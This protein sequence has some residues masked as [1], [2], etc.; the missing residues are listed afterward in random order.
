[1]IYT[2][3]MMQIKKFKLT[4][5]GLS[6]EEFRTNLYKLLILRGQ[7]KEAKHKNLSDKFYQRMYREEN[8]LRIRKY[9]AEYA[10]RR[11]AKKRLEQNV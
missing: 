9:H 6:E 4:K 1:M 3:F 5:Q 10:R 8:K 11:R 7:Y 2:K